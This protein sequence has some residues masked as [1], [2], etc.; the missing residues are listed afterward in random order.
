M[1]NLFLLAETNE[2]LPDIPTVDEQPDE[3]FCIN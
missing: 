2:N 3:Q 1:E